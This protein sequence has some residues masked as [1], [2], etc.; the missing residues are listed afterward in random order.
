MI[1]R[2]KYKIQNTVLRELHPYSEESHYGEWEESK[3][4]ENGLIV[5]GAI[6][7]LDDSKS[8]GVTNVEMVCNSK[9]GTSMKGIPESSDWTL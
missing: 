5:G 3:L 2:M 6:E 9:N 7:F 4:C 1:H 8:Y